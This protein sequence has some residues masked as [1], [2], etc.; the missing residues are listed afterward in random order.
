MPAA[1]REDLSLRYQQLYA[2]LGTWLYESLTIVFSGG[3]RWQE[4]LYIAHADQPPNQSVSI[5]LSERPCLKRYPP[6]TFGLHASYSLCVHVCTD[7]CLCLY[8]SVYV[9]VV[10]ACMNMCVHMCVEEELRDGIHDF[11]YAG[12]AFSWASISNCP[13]ILFPFPHSFVNTQSEQF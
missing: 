2:K 11:T 1:Q 6:L 12:Q 13:N 8:A 5:R 7:Q 10:R 9:S 4:E 3:G